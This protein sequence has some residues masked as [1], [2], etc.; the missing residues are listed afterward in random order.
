MTVQSVPPATQQ[1][2]APDL[3]PVDL[4]GVVL[5]ARRG[6][7]LAAC[8]AGAGVVALRTTRTGAERGMF[9][10][11]GVCQDCLVEV[12]GRANMRACM[13]KVDRPLRVRREAFGR[14]PPTAMIGA[15]PKTVDDMPVLRPDVLVV[16]GGPAGLAAALAARRAGADVLLLDERSALGGQYFKQP[17][18]SSGVRVDGQHET[19][20]RLVE[21][22]R[23]AGVTVRSNALVWGAFTP[24]EFAADIE[25]STA[26][27]CPRAAIIATGA[28]ERAWAVPGWTLPG[29]MTTGAAQ[30]LW[31][32]AGRLPGK[33]VLIAG[34]GPLNLQLATELLAGGAT[35]VAVVESA[36]AP[37]PAGIGDILRLTMAAPGLAAEGLRMVAACRRAG[38]PMIHE[39]HVAAIEQGEDGLLA[40]IGGRH[41]QVLEADIV[42]LGYGFVP[43]NDLLRAIGVPH[44]PAAGGYHLET[45]RDESGATDIAGLFSVGDCTRIAGAR[46]AQAEGALAGFA[47]ARHLGLAL[48]ADARTEEAR[49]RSASNRHHRFQRALWSLYRPTIQAPPSDSGTILCRCEEVTLGDVEAA[50]AE[51]LVAAGAIKRRTR[52]GMGRCQGRYCAPALEALLDT[53]QPRVHD[54]YSGFAPRVPVK[55]I[56]IA[57]LARP[58]DAP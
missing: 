35:V 51:G 41:G 18:V 47:A 4:D 37:S 7:S 34:N 15:A 56:R 22:V 29:V 2:T 45:M 6:E 44:A 40:R 27:L 48:S 36:S 38:V 49:A 23:E 24:L 10:G 20:R 43:S 53:R 25:G 50:F 28:Y 55:P 42:C 13:V 39:S 57:D 26:R 30:T 8:L 3:V 33:R 5:H 21:A 52:L 58:M 14:P 17:A 31:R 12:D 46:V 1:S 54:E 32:T 9:C 16:G 11:M 19:G